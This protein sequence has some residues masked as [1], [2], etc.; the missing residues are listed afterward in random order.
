[1]N[2]CCRHLPSA[3]ICPN[4]SEHAERSKDVA[5]RARMSMGVADGA[6]ARMALADRERLTMIVALS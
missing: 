5:A 2:R 3:R 1:M 6:K 4:A